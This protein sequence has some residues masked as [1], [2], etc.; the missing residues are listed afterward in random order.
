MIA[1]LLKQ[2]AIEIVVDYCKVRKFRWNRQKPTL[3]HSKTETKEENRK[4][5]L[6][7]RTATLPS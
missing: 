6:K 3:A 1:K 2:I 5:C 4:Y 7:K